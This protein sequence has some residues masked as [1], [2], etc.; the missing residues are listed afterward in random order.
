MHPGNLKHILLPIAISILRSPRQA[1]PASC[2]KP[3]PARRDSRTSERQCNQPVVS[4]DDADPSWPLPRVTGRTAAGHCLVEF[5]NPGGSVIEQTIGLQNGLNKSWLD[6]MA[7][8]DAST[9]RLSQYTTGGQND[10]KR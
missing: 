4:T 10:G 1:R 9:L 6:L 8:A 2:E 5:Q 3:L 7:A